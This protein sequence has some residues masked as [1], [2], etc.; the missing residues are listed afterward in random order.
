ME[1]SSDRAFAKVTIVIPNWNG[2]PWLDRCLNALQ[3]QTLPGVATIIVDDGSTDESITFVRQAYPAVQV[4]ELGTNTGFANAVDTGIQRATTPYVVLLNTDTEVFPDWLSNL[5]DCIERLPSDVA[6][7]NSQMVCMDNRGRI[8]D[9]GDELSWYGGATKRGYGQS[10]AYFNEAVEIFSPCAGAS[11]YR[12]SFL[13]ETGGFDADFFAYLEDVD[14]GLR[15]RLMWYRY[16]YQPKARVAH[17][18]HGSDLRNDRYIELITRNRL[19][20]FLRDYTAILLLWHAPKLLYGQV[21]FLIAYARPRSSLKGYR[22][23]IASIPNI[24]RKRQAVLCKVQIG[25]T[26]VAELLT[27]GPPSPSLS[28][29]MFWKMAALAKKMR[30]LA[31]DGSRA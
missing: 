5:V 28:A 2:M 4:I 24:Y 21:Y 27:V 11:L 26:E 29:M 16:Y 9:A 22:S 14:L 1:N 7:V 31:R 17:K 30:L 10:T 12:R 19:A 13:E 23:F 6:A 15:G 3:R 25:H 20:V 8:D 18:E